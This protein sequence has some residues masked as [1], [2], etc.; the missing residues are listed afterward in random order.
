MLLDLS[1]C[2]REG[3]GGTGALRVREPRDTR[4]SGSHELHVPLSYA[5]SCFGLSCDTQLCKGLC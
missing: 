2:R 5:L 3:E 1:F 4:Q